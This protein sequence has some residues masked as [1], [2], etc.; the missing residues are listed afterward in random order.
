MSFDYNLFEN[1]IQN[2]L[3][4]SFTDSDPTIGVDISDTPGVKVIFD[5]YGE[6]DDGEDDK[7]SLSYAVF[8][9]KNSGQPEF[10]FP[11]HYSAWGLIIHRPEEE[12][13][14]YTWYNVE[15]DSWD[16]IAPDEFHENFPEEK[17]LEVLQKL[18]D[19]YY[20]PNYDE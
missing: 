5:G 16:I 8:I 13:C 18:N 1:Y 20:N 15:E 12:I 4:D 10:E 9:H 2:I 11:Q 7:N 3:N 17:F 19:V 6:T 14:I